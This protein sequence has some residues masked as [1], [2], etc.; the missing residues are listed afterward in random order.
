MRTQADKAARF[1]ELHQRPGAFIIPN[2]WDAGTAKLLASMG[3][4]AL[5]TTSLGLANTLGRSTVSLDEI[6]ENC[7][8]IAEA[9]DLP[10]NA[11]LEN[12]GADMPKL[13]AEAIRFAAEAGAVGGSIEDSTGDPQR[14]IYDFTLAVERVQAAVEAARALPFPF[15]LTAR[16]ENFLHGRKDL[17]DTIKR[18]QA[19]EAAGADVVYSPGLY[20]LATIKAVVSSVKKPFNLVM[21]FADPT[22]TVEQLSAAGVKRISVGGA[23]QR[24]ALAA[25]LRC[26]REMKDNGAFSFV[27]DMAP[28]KEVR[29][30]FN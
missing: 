4:E 15:T 12:C 23:M 8:V 28:V 14:P 10:V 7:R 25:F 16:A 24:H 29:A 9:T 11:D 21:G 3:F 18:L 5:A 2:P 17:D 19:F 30:A 1:R 13:A 26:A 27:R 6:I 20:D 22:L